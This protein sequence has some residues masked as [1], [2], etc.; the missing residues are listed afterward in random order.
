[1]ICIIEKAE[2]IIE[3]SINDAKKK[4][5]KSLFPQICNNQGIYKL[6]MPLLGGAGPTVFFDISIG[7]NNFSII[8]RSR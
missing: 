2:T 4:L 6:Q 5:M 1:M 7:G 8:F 3:S